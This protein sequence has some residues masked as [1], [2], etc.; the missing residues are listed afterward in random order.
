MANATSG[1]IPTMTVVA[2]T[3]F[4]SWT[5]DNH[6]LRVRGGIRWRHE[7]PAGARIDDLR[8]PAGVRGHDGGAGGDRLE[9]RRRDA[10]ALP[11]E[12][13]GWQDEGRR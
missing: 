7:Q 5:T 13:D 10:L 8:D 3:D 9:Q 4:T 12:L 2:A 11:A 6:R 1:W